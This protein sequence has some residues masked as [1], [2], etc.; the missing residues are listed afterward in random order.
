MYVVQVSDFNA[1]SA[2]HDSLSFTASVR[3]H[4]AQRALTAGPFHAGEWLAALPLERVQDLHVLTAAIM[5]DAGTPG[6]TDV[7]GTIVMSV[8]GELASTTVTY[9]ES[10]I[11]EWTGMLFMMTD[12]EGKRRSGLE[13][14]FPLSFTG[15][16]E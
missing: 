6:F 11:K 5:K 14:P 7:L 15:D 13:L 9:D 2:S 4:I 12:L 1:K 3:A 8:A 10:Q 16:D